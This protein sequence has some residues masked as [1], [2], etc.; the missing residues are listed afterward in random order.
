M[1]SKSNVRAGLVGTVVGALG[2]TVGTVMAFVVAGLLA[3]STVGAY[4][5]AT[6][7]VDAIIAGSAV[8]TIVGLLLAGGLG[9]GVIAT[10]RW[11]ITFFGRNKAIA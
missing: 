8:A 5:L 2:L 4:A 7:I 1:N 3:P 10:I 11:S 9:A 6:K